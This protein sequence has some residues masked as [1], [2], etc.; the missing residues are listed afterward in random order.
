MDKAQYKMVPVEPT[1]EMLA[2]GRSGVS[3]AQASWIADRYAAMLAAAPQPPS[4][5]GERNEWKDAVDH[6]LVTM[7]STA[8]S[9]PTPKAAVAALINWHVSVAQDPLVNGLAPSPGIDAAGQ[10]P[11]DPMDW[12]LPCDVTVGAGTMR[13]GVKLRTLVLRMTV[14]HEMAM[15]KRWSPTLEAAAEKIAAERAAPPAAQPDAAPPT[16]AP[17][18]AQ[19]MFQQEYDRA[20]KYLAD[21]RPAKP[22][23]AAAQPAAQPSAEWLAEAV[24]LLDDYRDAV[25]DDDA[26]YGLNYE[27]YRT[28]CCAALLAHLKARP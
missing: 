27:P 14:L 21:I 28:E 23:Q 13:K 12:P 22:M 4:A 10:K 20:A 16:P 2:A 17:R 1:P 19:E 25:R 8:D 7:Q 11:D 24:R 3:Y 6:E 9:Y 5:S 18:T 15:G 26:S